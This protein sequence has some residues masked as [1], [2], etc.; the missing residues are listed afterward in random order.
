MTQSNSSSYSSYSSSSSSPS[1]VIS[2]IT[3]VSLYPTVNA[4]HAIVTLEL[5]NPSNGVTTNKT[6]AI[7]DKNVIRDIRIKINNMSMSMM[8][9]TTLLPVKPTEFWKI[10][11]DDT[12]EFIN[13]A[14][15]T[16][17]INIA[18]PP[19]PQRK[20]HTSVQHKIV[21]SPGS[22]KLDL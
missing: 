17:S 9:N 13:S 6:L 20:N 12:K 22:R 4:S 16:P 2:G 8:P 11:N 3:K 1:L 14:F 7:Y 5:T 19:Q 15:R 18:L 21:L 10:L